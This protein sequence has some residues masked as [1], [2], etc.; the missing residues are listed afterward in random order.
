MFIPNQTVQVPAAV[1]IGSWEA[2][3]ASIV[4]NIQSGG[5]EIGQS[6]NSGQQNPGFFNARTLLLANKPFIQSQTVAWVDATFNSGN[7]V[8]N[9]IKC[10]RD[11]GLILNAIAQDMLQDSTSDSTFA[12]IQYWNQGTYTGQISSE[13]T[14]TIAAITYLQGLATTVA[15]DAGGAARG[16]IVSTN[17]DTI[18]NILQT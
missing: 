7:F 10:E 17:F 1:A 15:T 13:I 3:T 6:I 8:Y 12:G 11:T 9:K 14:A 4:V 16:T 18:L 5:I 2:N